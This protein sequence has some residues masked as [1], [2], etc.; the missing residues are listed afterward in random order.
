M[1]KI[2]KPIGLPDCK[3]INTLISKANS[4]IDYEFNY[5]NH[6]EELR[7]V[8]SIEVSAINQLFPEYTPHDEHYH[9]KRLFYVADQMLGDDVIENMNATELFLLASCLYGHDWGMAVSEDEKESIC[10][11]KKTENHIHLL[12]DEALRFKE[13]CKNKNIEADKITISDWQEY[14]RLTHAFRSGKRIKQYFGSISSGIAEF[15]ARICEGHWLDFDIIDDYTSYPTDASIHLEIVNV[16][17]LTIY[18]RLVDLLDL[19][20]DRTPF[21]LWKFVAPRN[22]FSKLEW[23]KHRALQPVTF[24]KYQ[25]SRLIQVDG[26]TNDQNVYM[27]IL[28]LKRYVDMQF[29]QCQDIL[30]RINHSYHKLNISHIDWRIA[31]R[32]FEPI[33]IQFE[34]DRIRM[35]DILSDDIYRSNPYV[36]IRELMQNSIDAISMRKEILEKKGLTFIPKIQVDI[37]ETEIYYIVQI[38]DN[39]IGMDEY[40]VRNYLAVAGKSYYRSIDFRKEGLNMDPISRFGIGVLSCFMTS[41]FLE[42]E[43]LKDPNT[44]KTQES[45]RIV[46]PSKEN[47]FKVEKSLNNINVGTT[48][49]VF[50]IKDKLP[51]DNK[52]SKPIELGISEYIKKTAAFVKYPIQVTER[53]STILINSPNHNKPLID[54][55]YRISYDF[56]INKA[57][58]AQDI[59]VVNE[60]FKEQRFYMKED[61]G[62]MD[63]DGCL[64]Y[65]IPKSD[66]IDILNSALSW[67]TREISLIDYKNKITERKKIKWEDQWISFSRGN[68]NKDKT[69]INDRSYSVYMDG[70]LLQDINSPEI[71]LDIDQED[72]SHTDYRMSM[73]DT[74]INPQLTVNIPKPLGMKIDLARTNIES[75]ERWDKQIWLALIDN[76]KEFLIK[77]ILIKTP[78]E[79]LLSFAKLL[80]FYKLN[81]KILIEHL[82]PISTYPLPFISSQGI[83]NFNEVSKI[84]IIKVA[85]IEFAAHFFDLIQASYINYEKYDGVLRQYIGENVTF[86]FSSDDHFIDTPA[87]LSNMSNLNKYFLDSNYYLK[88]IEFI[89]SPLG[90]KFPLVQEIFEKKDKEDHKN[91]EFNNLINSDLSNI[92]PYTLSQINKLLK[93]NFDSFPVLT[94]FPQPYESKIFFGFKYLNIKNDL[95]K[96]FVYI[97]LYII[98]VKSDKKELNEITGKI[99]DMIHEVPFI[100]EY[101]SLSQKNNIEGFNEKIDKLFHYALEHNIH[102]RKIDKFKKITIKDF[103]ENSI[104]VS[105]T[106]K[107]ISG[108]IE[109]KKYL[110]GKLNWG[111]VIK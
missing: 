6:L 13:F 8:I 58:V 88:A 51:V 73:F 92:T 43:T 76:L 82:L 80:T 31:A 69:A 28:D 108:Y 100:K 37:T 78:Q 45:L 109:T 26:S 68:N 57:I 2:N 38:S 54:N 103:V 85:P 20:E 47:Y 30:N 64:T 14:V 75:N 63:F 66:D 5:V 16:K 62:L 94:S 91:I 98:N 42:I 35:F 79:R 102:M 49:K 52:T 83:L 10:S 87:S 25:L 12:D 19:G 33:A 107:V 89:S 81:S 50:M 65:L 111:Q 106:T 24:P 97:C 36:F 3:I 101:Y 17:A 22:N 96:F 59:D 95:A 27:S 90:I 61:L 39:G 56:P 70:I 46:I 99:M 72:E 41:D 53:N 29:R 93:K 60:Y 4:K 55:E 9:L 86:D 48:F 74:F 105:G 84:D 18:V 67:P 104:T 34:F 32:G 110:T 44:T 23:A 15:G 71:K 77:P 7:K 11:G 40:V 1:E 21:I